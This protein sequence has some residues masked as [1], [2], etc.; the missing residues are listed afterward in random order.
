MAKQIK[1]RNE[2]F[3]GELIDKPPRAKVIYDAKGESMF[4]CPH[5]KHTA[6]PEDC[7]ILG[8]EPGCLFCNQC[9]REFEM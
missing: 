5:C 1:S 2:L 7:D 9:N 3:R 8:A 4:V 6:H